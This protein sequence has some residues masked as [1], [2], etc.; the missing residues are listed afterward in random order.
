MSLKS[1]R[2][3]PHIRFGDGI[4]GGCPSRNFFAAR[5]R[6]GNGKQGNVGAETIKYMVTR[7]GGSGS[8]I[9]PRNPMPAQGGIEAEPISEVKLF[10]PGAFRKKLERAITADDYAHLAAL[11]PKSRRAESSKK[12]QLAAANLRWTGSWNEARVAID[13]FGAEDLTAE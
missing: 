13:P 1:T 6:I 7:I 12:V 3:A 2:R 5:Y 10:A 4:A 8:S 11:D 9:Q